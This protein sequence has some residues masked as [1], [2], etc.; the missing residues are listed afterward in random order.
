MYNP[1]NFISK[2]YNIEMGELSLLK[3]CILQGEKLFE[4]KFSFI[5]LMTKLEFFQLFIG[6]NSFQLLTISILLC[7]RKIKEECSFGNKQQC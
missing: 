1:F 7:F 5:C 4:D 2:I 6:S 3:Y